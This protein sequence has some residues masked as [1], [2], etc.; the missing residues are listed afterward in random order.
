MFA[1]LTVGMHNDHLRSGCQLMELAPYSELT[2]ERVTT[3]L[4]IEGDF[5]L[6]GGC[7]PYRGLLS[8]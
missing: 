3:T 5:G 2:N 8:S 7:C 6:S 1:Q 4:T